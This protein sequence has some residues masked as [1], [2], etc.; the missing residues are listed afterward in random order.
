MLGQ[1]DLPF[2]HHFTLISFLGDSSSSHSPAICLGFTI[3]GVYDF[4][5]CDWIVKL[6]IKKKKEKKQKE[7]AVK[8]EHTFIYSPEQWWEIRLSWGHVGP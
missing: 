6:K 1:A 8:N 3:L 5:V 2:L 7:N 4:C